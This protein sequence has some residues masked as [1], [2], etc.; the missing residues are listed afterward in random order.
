MLSQGRNHTCGEFEP[1]DLPAR[2]LILAFNFNALQRYSHL[3][4]AASFGRGSWLTHELED[5]GQAPEHTVRRTRCGPLS[6]VETAGPNYRHTLNPPPYPSAAATP[7]ASLVG[8]VGLRVRARRGL[9]C[10]RGTKQRY[11]LRRA[12][13]PGSCCSSADATGVPRAMRYSH[14]ASAEHW[15]EGGSGA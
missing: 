11:Q 15:C 4:G 14:L 13:L 5:T 9:L 12:E 6:A 8:P 10:A 7:Q 1:R 3:G 2:K